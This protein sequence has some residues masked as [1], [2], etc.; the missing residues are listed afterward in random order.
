MRF[1]TIV[2]AALALCSATVAHAAPANEQV[3]VELMKRGRFCPEQRACRS[4][5]RRG[6]YYEDCVDYCE[7]IHCE[8]PGRR[9]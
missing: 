5:C 9:C 2:L 1:S 3:E 6:Q 4:M 8:C 7:S